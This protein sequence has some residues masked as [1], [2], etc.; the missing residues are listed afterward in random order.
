MRKISLKII[1]ILMF[2]SIF[3]ISINKSYAQELPL[4][5]ESAIA[6]EAST[7]EVLYEK[8]AGQKIYPASTMDCT[9][10]YEKYRRLK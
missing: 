5:A 2:L 10:S 8:N 9:F 1:N 6:M 7:G 3:L 4:F